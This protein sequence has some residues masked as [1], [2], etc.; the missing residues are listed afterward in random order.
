[1]Q[2][3]EEKYIIDYSCYALLKARAEKVLTPDS[4]GQN[5]SY[6]ITSLYYDDP[7]D[8]ALLEKQDGL[9][10]H[11]KFRLRTYNFSD[12]IIRL[13]KKVKEGVLT[14]KETRTVTR[15]QLAALDTLSGD[16]AVQLRATGQR[17][18]I[19]V[20]YRR[21]AYVYPGTDIRL[22]F[23]RDLRVLP[24]DMQTLFDSAYGGIPV[25]SGNQVI[26]ELKYGTH[27][28]TFLRTLTAVPSQQLSVSKYALCRECREF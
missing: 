25:L 18:A 12:K 11:T 23:D 9:A 1:M 8:T 5:G 20:R 26:M 28:P 2:R 15:E 13:E 24:P 3:H 22:T 7:I 10:R 16:L 27:I 17:P 21:D 14:Q 4:N 6:V 19:T